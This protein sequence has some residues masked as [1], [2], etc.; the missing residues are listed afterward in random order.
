MDIAGVTQIVAFVEC[1]ESFEIYEI[2]AYNF[3]ACLSIRVFEVKRVIGFLV[4][5]CSLSGF[6]NWVSEF[7]GIC[8]WVGLGYFADY[9]IGAFEVD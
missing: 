4:C 6:R 3:I 9:K 1:Y 5:L 7:N 2:Y 8:F